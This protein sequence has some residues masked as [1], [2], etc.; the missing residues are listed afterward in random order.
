M[1]VSTATRFADLTTFRLGGA[2]ALTVRCANEEAIVE[3][4]RELDAAK[5]PY[6]VVGGGSNLL[7]AD[8]PIDMVAVVLAN[9]AV[10]LYEDGRVIAGAGAVWDDVVAAAVER[11][12]G[13]IEC[14]SGVPGSAGATSVQN[15]GAYGAEIAD[16]L[17]RVKLYDKKS[18][19]AA[20]VPA[21]EL[22]LAYR[23]SNLKFT[24]RGV[25]LAIELQLTTDGLSAP[26]RFGQLAG[27]S[28]QRRPVAEVRANVLELR[29]RKGMVVDPADHDTWSAGS[30]FTN[31]VVDPA[32]A[33][34][35]QEKVR[36]LR[37]DED[38]EAMPRWPV[39]GGE[40][41]SA[42]WL[43]DRAGFAKGYPGEGAPARLST[44]HTLALTN[45]GDATSTDIVN[46]ARDVRNGVRMA[47]GVTLEPEPV[48]I[49][50]EF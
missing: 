12:F 40:K 41:L 5:T 28:G 30:F 8:G 23:Y 14:L 50:L 32:L 27:E 10:T 22:E 2:P 15:V 34:S 4:C 1:Q 6:L 43:I 21:A 48:W 16:V 36:G 46:L 31:P 42:A 24:G 33:D 11:G 29:R 19:D 37:G 49:G 39:D 3:V 26:L 20:W 9:D 45:R 35:V 47:F 25:V 44:K 18:G 7:V 13:G 17:T 38:A